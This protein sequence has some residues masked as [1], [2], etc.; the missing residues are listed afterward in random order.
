MDEA[1]KR[2]AGVARARAAH[3]R[4]FGRPRPE[5]P[6]AE[7][8][9]GRRAA[10]RARRLPGA[11][12]RAF[13]VTP[14]LNVGGADRWM[15]AL[16]AATSPS[17]EWSAVVCRQDYLVI[18]E[19]RAEAER[20]APVV[21][22]AD[23]VPAVADAAD[24]CV[25]WGVNLRDLAAQLGPDGPP[26]VAVSHGVGNWTRDLFAEPGRANLVA[27]SRASL[28]TFPESRRGEATVIENCVEE[29]RL[30][31]RRSREEVRASWGLAPGQKALVMLGRLS[32]E[33]NPEAVADAVAEMHRRGRTEWVGVHVG[34][35]WREAEVKAHAEEVAPGLVRFPGVTDDVAAAYLAADSLCLPSSEEACS[36][37]M[38]EAFWVGAPLI[39]SRVGVTEEP[40]FSRL[41][42]L[43]SPGCPG[44]ELADAVLADAADPL[45]TRVRAL[46]ARLVARER[47]S[48]ARFARDWTDLLVGAADAPPAPVAR[49]ATAAPDPIDRLVNECEHRGCKTG[50]GHSI[51]KR[52]MVEVHISKCREC[53]RAA[54]VPA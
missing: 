43:V 53:R 1:E 52:D 24:L 27:V 50:C 51:C 46:R 22:G 36:L 17:V 35:G 25:A 16:M 11:R 31:P 47:F 28:R 19:I 9:A 15:L 37:M 18:P 32:P 33:K 30:V 5:P 29:A 21:L 8:R 20:H 42:R 3:E 39:A 12:P 10:Y 48:P 2:A 13:L 41:C 45:G 23:N 54:L 49:A 44:D 40:E 26:I 34:T 38:L 7:V 4:K 6:E 14:C